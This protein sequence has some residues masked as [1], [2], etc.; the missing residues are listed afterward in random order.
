MKYIRTLLFLM[1]MAYDIHP[2]TQSPDLII[3]NNDT[4][5]MNS[6]PINQIFR[7]RSRQI[8]PHSAGYCWRGYQALWVLK[9]DSLYLKDVYGCSRFYYYTIPGSSILY[10]NKFG[11]TDSVVNS[12]KEHDADSSDEKRLLNKEKI[13]RKKY[14]KNNYFVCEYNGKLRIPLGQMLS[15][16]VGW[17]SVYEKCLILTILKGILVEKSIEETKPTPLETFISNFKTKGKI[18]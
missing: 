10:L 13:V 1:L 9:N 5:R 14:I 7:K 12:F 17:R 15:S 3:I 4:L 6:S 2:T 18:I 11:L 8:K 16:D